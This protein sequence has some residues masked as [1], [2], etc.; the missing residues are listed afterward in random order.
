[1]TH[2]TS[3]LAAALILATTLVSALPASGQDASGRWRAT[4]LGPGGEVSMVF[5]FEVIG[6]DLT[7]TVTMG[8]LFGVPIEMGVV[9]GNRIAFEQ[10]IQGRGG[11]SGT[12]T[13][14][15]TGVVSADEIAFTRVS[16][17]GG[18]SDGGG[19]GGRGGSD[20]RDAI[21]FVAERVQ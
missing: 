14:D 16:A 3:M 8:P 15:Y 21:E 12:L 6:D 1:M 9:D 10:T 7:G 4:A 13:L 20:L 11:G 2:R 18:G 17:T 19:R 5:N